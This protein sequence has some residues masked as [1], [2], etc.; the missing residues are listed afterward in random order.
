MTWQTV[1]FLI[2][3]VIVIATIIHVVMDNR[4]DNDYLIDDK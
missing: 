4:R 3:Q 2:Y 1:L